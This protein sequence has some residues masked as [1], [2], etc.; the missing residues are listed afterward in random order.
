MS[1][2]RR[3]PLATVVWIVV[4]AVAF[5]GGWKLFVEVDDTS[6]FVL[7]P[8][9]DVW[10]A[11]VDLLGEDRTWHHARVTLTEIV[12]GFGAAAAVG[13]V[14][15]T[16]LGE[17]PRVAKVVNP[18]IV[19]L[20]VLPKV[21]VI[22]LFLLWMGFGVTTN[23][24]IAAMFAF[25]P[26]TTGTRNGIRSVDPAQLDLASTL[27][28]SRWRRLWLIDARSALPS[29][30]TGAEV[31]IVLSTVG[32]V[33]AEFLAGGRDGLG[34]LAVVNLNSLRVD[35]MFAVVAMLCAMGVA[36]YVLVASLRRWLIPWHPSARQR[37]VGV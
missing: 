31:A 22:P 1:A 21:A 34:H 4:V 16:I 3:F 27:Q 24:T 20:Q 18:Y 36:L 11:L 33:V 26:M 2:H 7:P 13:I 5:V 6:R 28:M 25:F 37:P 32:A 17:L 15:G 8:P 30:L 23:I 14:L 10:R 35:R 12:V 19:V 29:I 9:E